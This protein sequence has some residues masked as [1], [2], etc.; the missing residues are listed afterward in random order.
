MTARDK[1]GCMF[2]YGEKAEAGSV[3]NHDQRAHGHYAHHICAE[4]EV[5]DVVKGGLVRRWQNKNKE[6][7]WLDASYYADVAAAI[8]GVRV[9]GDG[10]KS[11]P[12]PSERPSARDLA[13][14]AGR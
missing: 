14:K 2:L 12:S 4:V 6:N 8:K 10:S 7:H 11:R 1:A 9:M 3:L 5:E 13:A